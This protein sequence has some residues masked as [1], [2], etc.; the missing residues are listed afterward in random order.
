MSLAEVDT[1]VTLAHNVAGMLEMRMEAHILL[2]S[3]YWATTWI[4]SH[5]H[6]AA[7]R[8]I[9]NTEAFDPQYHPEFM[10]GVNDHP[11]PPLATPTQRGHPTST[12]SGYGLPMPTTPFDVLT[13][14]PVSH[15]ARAA[16]VVIF[17]YIV[18]RPHFY[19]EQIA[20]HNAANPATPFVEAPGP[21]FTFVR[22]SLSDPTSRNV[23]K[24]DVVADLIRNGIPVSWIDQAYAFSLR[25]LDQTISNFGWHQEVAR[26]DSER[27]QR[28]Q[29]FGMPPTLPAWSGWWSPSIDNVRQIR[30]FFFTNPAGYDL[31]NPFWIPFGGN[32]L[33]TTLISQLGE[34]IPP[35]IVP[36]WNPDAP[37]LPPSLHTWPGSDVEPSASRLGQV[38]A[39]EDTEMTDA[40]APPSKPPPHDDGNHPKVPSI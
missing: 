39:S 7:M 19:A 22:S 3:F 15:Q 2:I 21:Q 1:L 13:Q 38:A 18:A 5:H 29:R 33:P 12:G 40:H 14:R 8:H 4:D 16:W 34:E 36:M 30:Y 24:D 6:D 20:Q 11:L 28:L 37:Q 27:M 35:F 26:I 10:T 25:L 17:A 9:L 31:N 23:T 32:P